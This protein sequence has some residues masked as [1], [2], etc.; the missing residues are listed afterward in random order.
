MALE[1]AFGAARHAGGGAGE[2]ISGGIR[3]NRRERS[4]ALDFQSPR[5]LRLN[6][7]SCQVR[8][9]D[10]ADEQ[11]N[12]KFGVLC[13]FDEVCVER[14]QRCAVMDANGCNQ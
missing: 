2:L 3:F 5:S 9:S 14:R 12:S 7:L 8:A 4:E 11:V 1:S 13:E 10:W 6:E